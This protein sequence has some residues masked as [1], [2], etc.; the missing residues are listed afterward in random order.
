M[1]RVRERLS[2]D[3]D[4]PAA[5]RT[6]DAWADSALAGRGT[7]PAAVALMSTCV[8]ALLGVRAAAR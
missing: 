8:D 4:A 3:L 1:A 7:D 5:L 2:D 6:I